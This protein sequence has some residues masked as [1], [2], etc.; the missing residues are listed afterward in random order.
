MRRLILA[1][2]L[3]CAGGLAPAFA[4]D[5]NGRY[6]MQSTPEGFLKMD[7]RTGAV[8]QCAR[9]GD[10]YQCRL[11]PDER[12]AMQEEIDRLRREN[13]DLRGRIAGQGIAPPAAPAPGQATPALPPD[14]EV[15]RALSIMERFIRR[16]RDIMREDPGDQKL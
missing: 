13:A 3:C 10:A 12:N 2:A 9:Q 8:S 4:Q 5:A 1:A 6:V 16:F 11:V 14:S 7:S 15:E